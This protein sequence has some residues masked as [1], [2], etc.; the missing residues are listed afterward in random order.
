MW[1]I[2]GKNKT[3]GKGGSR[4]TA[5]TVEELQDAVKR[6]DALHV[7][8]HCVDLWRCNTCRTINRCDCGKT[9]RKRN[10]VEVPLLR[11][12]F[13]DSFFDKDKPGF[14]GGQPQSATERE[15]K[16]RQELPKFTISEDEKRRLLES[17]DFD[18]SKKSSH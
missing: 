16:Y 6:S 2:I 11:C 9:I 1:T 14:L 15:V 4:L 12:R 7:M 18:G 3:T 10:S 13:C 17:L 5:S 8:V